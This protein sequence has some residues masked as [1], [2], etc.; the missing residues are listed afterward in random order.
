MALLDSLVVFLVSLLVGALGIYVGAR[1]VAGHDD[2]TYAIVTALL[3]AVV[4][5]V[6]GFFFGWIPFLGPLLVLLAY[7]AVINA[8]YPGGWGNAILIALIAWVAS[9]AVLYLLALVGIA[10]FDAVGVPGA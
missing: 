4:W 6:V 1:V 9:L 10:G 2:Y 8:R 7:V 5:G 3:G